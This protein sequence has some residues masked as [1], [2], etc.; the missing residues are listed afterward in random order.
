MRKKKHWRKLKPCAI[1]SAELRTLLI[2]AYP[3]TLRRFSIE[4]DYCHACTKQHV[5]EWG[6]RREWNKM[7][8]IVSIKTKEGEYEVAIDKVVEEL[9]RELTPVLGKLFVDACFG[10]D[11]K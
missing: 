2:Q 9:K 6:A 10:R 1:C 3:K 7:T 8:N 5:T 11:K 4:C